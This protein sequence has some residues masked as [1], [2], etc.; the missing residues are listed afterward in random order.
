[1]WDNE[2][3]E[4]YLKKEEYQQQMLNVLERHPALI[5]TFPHFRSMCDKPEFV[6]D[7]LNKYNNVYF[8]NVP[9]S[10]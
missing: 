6:E 4:G 8:D 9:G 5:V 3:K 7:L 10:Y 2:Y 1:M